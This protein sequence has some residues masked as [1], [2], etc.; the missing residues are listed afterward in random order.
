MAA[1]RGG[2][3]HEKIVR[4]EG[5]ELARSAKKAQAPQSYEGSGIQVDRQREQKLE[6]ENGEHHAIG[7]A[8]PCFLVFSPSAS[9]SVWSTRARGFSFFQG[10]THN[11][12]KHQ[13]P[14]PSPHS[15]SFT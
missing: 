7:V 4:G 2:G 8:V 11:P 6:G 12:Q 9:R 5:D 13:P 14:P 1:A 3:T 10:T 15:N